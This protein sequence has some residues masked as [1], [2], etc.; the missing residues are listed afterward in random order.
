MKLEGNVPPSYLMWTDIKAKELIIKILMKIISN[1]EIH[2]KIY[3]LGM[4]SDFS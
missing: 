2:F 1:Y 3:R 4:G